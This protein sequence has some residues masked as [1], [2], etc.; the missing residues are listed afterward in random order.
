[1]SSSTHYCCDFRDSL[2]NQSL[3]LV[4]TT[5]PEQP[6][7][8]TYTQSDKHKTHAKENYRK[9]EDGQPGLVAFHNTDLEMG[10]THSLAPGVH[11]D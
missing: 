8:K 9:T 3:A 5:E 1:M 10:R 6:R 4:P 11:P 7:D 2:S